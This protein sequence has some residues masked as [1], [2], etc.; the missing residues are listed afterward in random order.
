MKTRMQEVIDWLMQTYQLNP[1]EARAKFEGAPG[2]R[3]TAWNQQAEK[4]LID[5][6]RAGLGNPV[7][8]PKWAGKL[9]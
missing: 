9:R 6:R 8:R 1:E 2:E 5:R 3:R 7:Y 4:R